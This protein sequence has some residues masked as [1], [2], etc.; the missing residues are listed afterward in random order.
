[1][2]ESKQ[3][4]SFVRFE[5]LVHKTTVYKTNCTQFSQNMIYMTFPIQMTINLC[6]GYRHFTY[7]ST[8]MFSYQL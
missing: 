2:N 4:V 5:D 6:T 8:T 1:M 7:S 3:N